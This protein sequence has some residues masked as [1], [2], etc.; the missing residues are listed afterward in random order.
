MFSWYWSND[1]KNVNMGRQNIH[2]YQFTPNNRIFFQD[3]MNK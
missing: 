1:S 3:L 2:T